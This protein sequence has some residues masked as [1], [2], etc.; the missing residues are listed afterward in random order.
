[1]RALWSFTQATESSFDPNNRQS[2]LVITLYSIKLCL[3]CFL[4]ECMTSKC[5]NTYFTSLIFNIMITFLEILYHLHCE[6]GDEQHTNPSIYTDMT[7]DGT[8][9]SQLPLPYVYKY[10]KL[11]SSILIESIYNKKT[12]PTIKCILYATQISTQSVIATTWLWIILCYA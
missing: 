4:S 6:W 10:N 7:T 3:L 9:L 5:I 8:L 11:H 1:M 12:T 2:G